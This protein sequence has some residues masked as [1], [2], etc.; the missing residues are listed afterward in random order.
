M[1]IGGAWLWAGFERHNMIWR[2]RRAD[3]AATASARPE[4]MRRWRA[5]SGPEAMARLADGRFLVLGEGLNDRDATSDAVL[6]DG[7][8]ALSRHARLPAPLP[9]G[10]GLSGDRRRL[11][12]GRAADHPQPA[13]RLARGLVR[14]W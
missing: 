4:P 14:R 3:L 13:L 12:A 5:N 6:F 1:V 7:D 8:P 2:Y 11:A 9:A 10:A